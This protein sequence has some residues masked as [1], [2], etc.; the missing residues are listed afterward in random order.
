M[1]VAADVPSQSSTKKDK[2]RQQQ[3][4]SKIT[5]FSLIQCGCKHTVNDRQDLI[6]KDKNIR[7]KIRKEKLASLLASFQQEKP[8]TTAEEWKKSKR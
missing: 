2:D 3:K 6:R 5:Q 4:S 1:Q 8:T 7:D